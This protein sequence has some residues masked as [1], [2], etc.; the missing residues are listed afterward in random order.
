METVLTT[1]LNELG[2]LLADTVLVLD[3]YHLIESQAIHEALAF[4]VDHLPPRM[5]LLICTRADPPLPLPR[6]RARGEMTEVRASDLRFTSE[7]AATFLNQVMGLELSAEDIAELEGRTEGWIA[8]LQMAAL[9]MTHR[10]D[11]AGFI[12]SFTGSNR[13]VVDYLGEEVLGRQPEELRTFLLET[14]I[15]DRMSAPLCR[16]VAG[17]TDGQTTLERLEHANLFVI[18]LDDERRWYRYHHLF[19][20]VLR[21]RLSQTQAN[22]APELHQRASGW[23]EGEGLVSEAIHHALAARDWERA[24][25]LI[26]SGGMAVVLSRQVQTMLAWIDE[27]PEELV[28]ERPVLC[29]MHA[30]ALV[31]L[32]RPGAAEARLQEAERCLRANPTTDEARAVLG[33]AAVIRAAIARSC[34]DLERCVEHARKAL[35]LLPETEATLRERAAA[36]ANVGLAYQVS[37]DVAPANERPLEEAIASFR[38]SGAQIPL[39]H[40]INFLARMRMLQGRLRTAA[41]TYE[42]VASVVLGRDGARDLVNSAGYYEGLGDI[43][44]EWNDLDSAESHL[45]RA[46]DLV[47][48]ALMVDADVVTHGYLSLARVQLA[49]GRSPDALATLQEFTNLA[50]QRNFFPLLVARGEAA[51]A[52]LALVHGDLPAAVRWAEA[53]GLDAGDEPDYRRE[54][55]YL[56][57][58]R[59]FIAQGRV[60]PMGSYLDYALAL[61]DRLLGAA[62]GGG[63]MGSVIEIVALR[64]LALK[65]RHESGEALTALE[66]ALALAEP[67]GYV[68]LFVDEGAAMKTLLSELLKRRRKEPRDAR[69]LALLGYARRLLTAF[70]SPHTST[71]AAIGR[72]S[73][74]DQLLL[75]ALT[76]R[77]EEVLALIADGLSNPEIAVRLFIATSTVKGYVHSI[78]RKLDV[79]SRT[80]VVARARELLLISE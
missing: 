47:A 4:L 63:R 21:Q 44:R 25:R 72:A 45:R 17:R 1:L 64:A 48:G 18:A 15:L 3:D 26:E 78:F 34:G 12:A 37:G 41:A 77:E 7:E 8:G 66:R 71:E 20:D 57:L 67:E 61:L 75:D 11:V 42:E 23:F 9:A 79:D 40:G 60:D 27:I 56:T 70:E 24:V 73:D 68:R 30:L 69:Q 2:D 50:R 22:L 10:D 65:A 52:R 58:V 55:Q 43:Q 35:E 59:I 74:A 14:S 29:T 6:L 80:R 62:E 13:H 51:R 54:E 32:N 36:G 76:P 19:A 46:V 16:A 33:R 5:H 39:L 49:R 53:S 28:R 38:V 31:F